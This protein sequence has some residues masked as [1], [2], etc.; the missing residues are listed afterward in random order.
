MWTWIVEH[1][2][3]ILK[4]I[5]AVV[6]ILILWAIAFYVY[7]ALHNTKVTRVV[8]AI[9]IAIVAIGAI[10]LLLRLDVLFSLLIKIFTPSI[11]IALAIVCQPE[12]REVLAHI[13]EQINEN[14]WL[15]R[16]FSPSKVDDEVTNV[17]CQAIEKLANKRIGALFAF[18]RRDNLGAI[19]DTGVKLDSQFSDALALTLFNTRT[20]LHDGGLVI[21]NNRIVAAGCIFP[22]SKQELPDRT[23]GLRHRAGLGITETSDC[24]AVIVS[25]ETGCI[26]LAYSGKLERN[27][28]VNML[29]NRLGNFLSPYNDSS[30][31]HEDSLSST[32]P[33]FKE[34]FQSL[35]QAWRT[36]I[37][38]Y[39]TEQWQAK[40][41]CFVLAFTVWFVVDQSFVNNSDLQQEIRRS[42]P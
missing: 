20:P 19:A 26:A 4:V 40:L 29:K 36:R 38:K 39:V 9:A 22:V 27:L 7:K 16:F 37:K 8:V 28:N 42:H 23:L 32:R 30:Q 24:I 34:K 2:Q 14:R 15:S 41:I 3:D 31:E 18:E 33:P 10:S 12:L 25:E 13:M 21:A 35:H 1:H 11:A 6:E 5:R 17:F